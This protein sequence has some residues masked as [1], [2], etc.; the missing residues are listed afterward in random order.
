MRLWGRHDTQ[1]VGNCCR[2]VNS[3]EKTQDTHKNGEGE[4]KQEGRWERKRKKGWEKTSGP[5]M[6][7]NERALSD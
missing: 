2:E 6:E 1:W 5:S 3:E 7:C 4:E